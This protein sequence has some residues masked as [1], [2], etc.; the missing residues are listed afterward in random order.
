MILTVLMF[1][2][3]LWIVMAHTMEQSA[4]NQFVSPLHHIRVTRVNVRM[5]PWHQLTAT[6]HI[7]YIQI[8]ILHLHFIHVPN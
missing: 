3:S 5:L 7:L 4:V 1:N 6:K 8:H 2:C